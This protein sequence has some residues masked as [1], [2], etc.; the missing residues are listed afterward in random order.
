MDKLVEWNNKYN[1]GLTE[2]DS[3]HVKL[4]DLINHFYYALK[5][6]KAKQEL[7]D[8]F[9][10]ANDYTHYHFEV[11]EKYFEQFDYEF[12]DDHVAQHIYFKE[13]INK[14]Q[15]RFLKNDFKVSFELMNLL[16]DWL[17]NHILKS[18]TMYVSCFKYNGI[19]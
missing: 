17:I 14:L 10:Q 16:R 13:E 19:K 8:I 6:G 1:T 15:E 9:K 5:Q 4:V 12:K 7:D 18:D 11:E 2:I 3:Q